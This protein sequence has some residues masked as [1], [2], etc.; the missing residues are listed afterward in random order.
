MWR[1]RQ[2]LRKA[3][4]FAQEINKADDDRK[5]ILATTAAVAAFGGTLGLARAF[6]ETYFAAL[7]GSPTRGKVMGALMRMTEVAGP[8]ARRDKSLLSDEDLD[9]EMAACEQR[10]A[11]RILAARNAESAATGN[12]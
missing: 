5:V 1:D 10:I 8:L 7:P 12:S 9:R 11:D 3:K 4:G 2:R 6:R